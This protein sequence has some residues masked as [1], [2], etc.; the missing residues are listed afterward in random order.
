MDKRR[1]LGY[2]VLAYALLT[3]GALLTVALGWAQAVNAALWCVYVLGGV[4]LVQGRRWGR[5]L[6][7]LAA[8]GT[9]TAVAVSLLVWGGGLSYLASFGGLSNLPALAIFVSALLIKPQAGIGAEGQAPAGA[10]PMTGT[11]QRGRHDRAYV[12]FMVLGL[13]AL[14]TAYLAFVDPEPNVIGLLVAVPLGIPLLLGLIFG[15]GLSLLIQH[16]LRL[17]ALTAASVALVVALGILELASWPLVLVPY[18]A[19]CV[20]TSLLWFFRGRRVFEA[21]ADSAATKA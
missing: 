11:R 10:V 21:K 9:L 12:S 6:T 4:G 13:I 17:L 3:S 19:V 15:P 2:A 5:A 16:D 20:A 8:G 7:L 1:L 18:G 14:W